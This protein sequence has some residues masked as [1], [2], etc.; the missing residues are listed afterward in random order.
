MRFG[1]FDL[2]CENGIDRTAHWFVRAWPNVTHAPMKD[3]FHATKMVTGPLSVRGPTHDLHTNFCQQLSLA[4]LQFTEDSIRAAVTECGNE[5]PEIPSDRLRHEVV[6]TKRFKKK[7]YN[8]TP[9]IDVA[10]LETETVWARLKR[11]DEMLRQ[12]AAASNVKYQ[13]YILSAVPHVR[14]GGEWEMQNF[15]LHLRKGC[16]ADPLP[17]EEMSY[18]SKPDSNSKKLPDLRRVRGTNGAESGNKQVN[19]ASHDATKMKPE[20]SHAKVHLRMN[21]FNA[22]KDKALE[23]ITGVKAKP[24]LWFLYEEAEKRGASCTYLDLEIGNYPPVL[25]EYSEPL[26]LRFS[27]QDNWTHIDHQ[28]HYEGDGDLIDDRWYTE[29]AYAPSVAAHQPAGF[30]AGAT[31]WNRKEGHRNRTPLNK[32]VVQEKLTPV[33]EQT[34]ADICINIQ[35]S[36]P[37]INTTSGYAKKVVELWN[38]EHFSRLARGQSSLGGS[39]PLHIAKKRVERMCD[40]AV[41]SK[42]GPDLFQSMFL[43]VPAYAPEVAR[44]TPVRSD[45]KV[46]PILPSRP[47]SAQ[48]VAVAS[49]AGR[50]KKTRVLPPLNEIS[51]EKAQTLSHRDLLVY[52]RQIGGGSVPNRKDGH[53]GSLATVLDYIRSRDGAAS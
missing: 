5:C 13:S 19:A 27:R 37:G 39:L 53:K 16:Y 7:M 21:R 32:Y 17:P 49:N 46:V 23:Q 15:L 22:D 48:K 4:N 10:A 31:V 2:C 8:F 18:V 36:Y 47:L 42:G 41:A 24:H 44:S 40:L 3:L 29:P 1:Y 11:E 26:G 12:E 28:L 30:S 33:Q 38:H 9:E 50:K 34:I 43:S 6:R 25:G 45:M 52:T 20:L 14:R 51:A 35:S